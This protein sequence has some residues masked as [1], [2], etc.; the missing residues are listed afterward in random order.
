VEP[1][2]VA[3]GRGNA[4]HLDLVR[5]AAEG[6][7]RA[8]RFLLFGDPAEFAAALAEAEVLYGGLDAAEVDRAPRLRW[9]HAPS[10]GVDRY[11]LQALAERG[12]VLT[13]ARGVYDE[14]M[15]EHAL[16]LLLA[17]TRRIPEAV[18]A[19]AERR[20]V[21]TDPEVLAGQRLGVLGFG[22]IGRAVAARARAFGMEIWAF[23]ARPRP[24]PLADRVLGPG[25]EDLYTLLR[26]CPAV[27]AVLPSTPATRGLLDARAFAAM[28]PGAR[29]VNLGRGDLVVETDLVDALRTGH[30]AGAALD[31]PPRDPLP[32]DSPLWGL[33]QVLITPHVGGFRPGNAARGMAVFAENV[34][35]YCRGEPLL[36]VVDLA[37]GY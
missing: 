22:S 26:A 7:G 15:A 21:R 34:A 13:N 19:Q 30:L 32:P 36:H 11:P 16:A 1:L 35:R 6:A 8:V 2:V 37:A 24:D 25:R 4:E 5:Q 14:A 23:R 28:P 20:W 3:L 9:V 10:A 29:L 27:V 33:P 17:L 12:I 18:R 31:T